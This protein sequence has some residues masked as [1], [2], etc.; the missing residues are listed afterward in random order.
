ML[1]TSEL[2]IITLNYNIECSMK[3]GLDVDGVL[4]PLK[5]FEIERGSKLFKKSPVDPNANNIEKMFNCSKL[6]STKFWIFNSINYLF[7]QKARA[8]AAETILKLKNENNEIYIITSRAKSFEKNIIGAT[9]RFLLKYWLKR[10]NIYYDNIYY[11]QSSKDKMLVC[12]E[13]DI[14]IMIDDTIENI[15]K[16]SKVTKTIL[17]HDEVEHSKCTTFIELYNDINIFKNRYYKTNNE[18]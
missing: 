4:I 1:K 14:D 15:K 13:Q 17:F 7:C 8:N 6:E 10:E 12:K 3:I 5:K 16:I 2:Y 9:S 18:C 11:C